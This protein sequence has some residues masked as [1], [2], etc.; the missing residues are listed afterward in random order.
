[1]IDGFKFD[2]AGDGEHFALGQPLIWR[3]GN[4]GSI[5]IPAGHRFNISAPA[6]LRARITKT[7]M[8]RR[9]D[10]ALLAACVH[11]YLLVEKRWSR[12]AAGIQFYRAMI[13]GG[14]PL[15]A[16]AVAPIALCVA[17]WKSWEDIP[18]FRE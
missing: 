16:V 5:T 17:L 15:R 10:W 1:M 11:D 7:V 8:D 18:A 6:A 3:L 12:I 13:R 4:G 14:G 9:W 2:P